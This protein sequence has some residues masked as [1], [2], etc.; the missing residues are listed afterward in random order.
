MPEKPKTRRGRRVLDY[1]DL[2][3]DASLKEIQEGADVS[4]DTAIAWRR[5]HKRINE[6]MDKEGGDPDVVTTNEKAQRVDDNNG[7]K[8][9]PNKEDKGESLKETLPPKEGQQD[10]QPKPENRIVE[11]RVE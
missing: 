11:F 6:L 7:K 4:K 8:K 3:P 1:L 5:R 10:K 2:H 9:T